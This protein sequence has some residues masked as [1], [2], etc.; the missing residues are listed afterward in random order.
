LEELG[1]LQGQFARL[2]MEPAAEELSQ[3]VQ[4][5]KEFKKLVTQAKSKYYMLKVNYP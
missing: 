5:E 1:R 4:T 3:A 2:V